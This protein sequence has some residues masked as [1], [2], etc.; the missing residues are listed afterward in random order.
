M[1]N[2]THQLLYRHLRAVVYSDTI[3]STVVSLRQ[4]TCAQIYS[5]E[6]HWIKSYPMKRKSEAHLTLS[7]LL[8]DVGVFPTIVTDNAPELIKGEFKKKAVHAG[9]VMHPKEVYTHNQNLAESAIRELRRM[10]KRVM[11]ETNAPHVLW[12]YCIELIADLR[13]HTALNI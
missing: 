4:N 3:F 1:K 12:D 9:A 6:F 11:R 5:T 2:M 10:Y 7:I 8:H 13:S